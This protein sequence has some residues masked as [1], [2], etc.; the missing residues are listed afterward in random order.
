MI[1]IHNFHIILNK[2][3]ITLYI[4]PQ[5]SIHHNF[6]TQFLSSN[7]VC[8]VAPVRSCLRGLVGGGGYIKHVSGVSTHS[9]SDLREVYQSGRFYLDI[10]RNAFSPPHCCTACRRLEPQR[11]RSY[12]TRW[13]WGEMRVDSIFIFFQTTS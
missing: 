5:S 8:I 6:L 4:H 7:C 12:N 13:E 1:K 2:Y 10:I 9:H 11:R 3:T